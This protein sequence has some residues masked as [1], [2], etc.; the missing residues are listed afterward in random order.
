MKEGRVQMPVKQ[1][2]KGVKLFETKSPL[3]NNVLAR[4]KKCAE[5]RR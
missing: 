3:P 4:Q 5:K 2:E 1:T